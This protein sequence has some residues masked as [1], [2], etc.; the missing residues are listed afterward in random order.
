MPR[1]HLN[2]GGG[3]ET[4]VAVEVVRQA[5]VCVAHLLCGVPFG[6]RFI[7]RDFAF[8]WKSSR[9][10]VADGT[11]SAAIVART[12]VTEASERRGRVSEVRVSV[13]LVV[14]REVIAS[15]GGLM[16]I[17]TPSQY[18]ALRRRSGASEVGRRAS[19][20][21]PLQQIERFD[22]AIQGLLGWDLDDALTFEHDLDHVPGVAIMDAVMVAVHELTGKYMSALALEFPRF[23]EFSP[24]SILRASTSAGSADDVVV[25]VEQAGRETVTGVARIE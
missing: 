12:T 19:N 2:A 18:H 23:T 5:G 20:P 11:G 22:N 16:K 10:T 3:L 24:P 1:E 17:A 9:S 13:D 8:A 25:S 4:R 14:H 7:M 21:S 6:N 15:G